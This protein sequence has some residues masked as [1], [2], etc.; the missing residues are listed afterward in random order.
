MGYSLPETDLTFRFLLQ[1]SEPAEE[2][3]FF[4]VNLPSA[5][6]GLEA[7]F[8]L[9]KPTRW[10]KELG[11]LADDPVVRIADSLCEEIATMPHGFRSHTLAGPSPVQRVLSRALQTQREFGSDWY[12]PFTAMATDSAL[13]IYLDR[14]TLPVLF[15]W[16]GLQYVVKRIAEGHHGV[17]DIHGE[18]L[19]EYGV[20]PTLD[21]YL[22]RY[23][24]RDTALT[25]AGLLSDVGLVTLESGRR[26][27]RLSA[28]A[29]S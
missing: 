10:R 27:I 20:M 13:L 19:Q 21:W 25:L 26:R 5:Q 8:D 24:N 2:K 15:P 18:S 1:E 22:K 14:G 4:V 9:I 29:L 16:S 28:A 23:V 7:R 3:P 11:S 12:V 6:A 17:I